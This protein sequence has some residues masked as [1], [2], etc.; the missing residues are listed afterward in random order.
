MGTAGHVDHGKTAL[1][2]AL[3]NYDCDT[4]K[5]E[6]NRGITIHLGFTHL[7][8]PNGNSIGI[9]DVPGHKDFI[10]TMISG[11]STIDFVLLTVAADSSIMPQTREHLH[12]MELLGI[13]NGII[14]LT[15][16][17]L[18][19]EEILE[20][21]ELEIGEF[22][23]GTFLEH[24]PIIRTSVKDNTGM[25][26]LMS[27]ISEITEQIEQRSSGLFFRMYIDRIFS[28]Q[29]FGTVINGSVLQGKATK[30]TVLYVL[31][32]SKEL[33]IRKMEHHGKE[34]DEVLSGQRASL[35]VVGLDIQNFQRGMLV[36]ERI[37]KPTIMID[38]ELTLFDHDRAFGIWNHALF[39]MGTFE[40]QVR[41][42]LLDKDVLQGGEKGLVQ[43]H[44]EKECFPIFG[45][46]FIVRSTSGDITL[47]GGKVLDAY[48][49]HHKK[50]TSHIIQHVRTIADGDLPA[51][52]AAEVRK[53]P[54][55]VTLPFLAEIS[56]IPE[57]DLKEI[58]FASIP[59]DIEMRE[60]NQKI[61]LIAL[62]RIGLIKG[63]ISKILTKHHEE[64]P[65]IKKG[66]TFEEI[67][68][69]LNLSTEYDGSLLSMLLEEMRNK[70]VLRKIEGTYA[71]K[72]KDNS[73][74]DE[75]QTK[76]MKIGQFIL[77]FSMK[78]PLMNEIK[79]FAQTQGMSQKELHDIINFLI[80]NKEIVT[81]ESSFIHAEII[82]KAKNVLIAHFKKNETLLL[83]DFRDNLQANRKIC[84]L[85]LSYF[86]D[87]GW[88]VRKGDYRILSEKGK[89]LLR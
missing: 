49:L 59:D 87:R 11:A 20:L 68:S 31:P 58:V 24:S 62:S 51:F 35:N 69:L 32:G 73:L 43:I 74:S 77:D 13:K 81:I 19:D 57:K 26:E 45:D 53:Q 9:I 37:I 48:P 23:E 78:V 71:L 82:E 44:L 2:K 16:C 65:L 50:R 27:E 40:D 5:D 70:D 30:N 39:L 72:E 85:L 1:I 22:V 55:A 47:G 7:D 21:V 10:N 80:E 83:S 33:R 63:K 34:V 38:A 6:K 36:S 86:D 18:V 41:I 60:V 67:S 17:D 88:T 42:H 64:N 75:A 76:I 52:I 4:H 29:G 54:H 12:I 3:T 46:S 79:E 66:K 8:L 89:E 15:K 14:A 61:L 84:L 25:S 28:V 56:N